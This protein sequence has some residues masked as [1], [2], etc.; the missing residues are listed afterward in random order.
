MASNDLEMGAKPKN[1]RVFMEIGELKPELSSGRRRRRIDR[2]GRGGRGRGKEGG[3]R[4]GGG[5]TVIVKKEKEEEKK[6]DMY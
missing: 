5:E 2:G 1:H 3:I 6:A 4:V